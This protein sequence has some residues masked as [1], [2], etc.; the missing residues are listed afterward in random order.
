MK[1]VSVCHIIVLYVRINVCKYL[2]DSLRRE[3]FF[4]SIICEQ[5][6]LTGFIIAGF[7][8]VNDNK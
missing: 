3:M 5:R 2:P 1:R 6:L 7:T 8:H 4:E